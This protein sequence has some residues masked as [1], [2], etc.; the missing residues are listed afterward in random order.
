MAAGLGT[1]LSPATVPISKILLPVF[2]RPMIYY[3][4]SVLMM[5]DIKDILVITNERDSEIFKRLLGD[6]SQFGIKIEYMIQFVQRGISDAFL[7]AK[8]WIAGERVALILGDNI[9]YSEKFESSIKEAITTESGAIIFGY[10]V[11]DPERFGIVE[12]DDDMKVISLEEKPHNPKSNYAVVGLYFYNDQVCDIAKTLKPSSRGELE[13]TDL[14]IEYMNKGDLSAFIID[15][16]TEWI[17]AGTF[18]SILESSLFI[19]NLEKKLGKKVMCPELLAFEKKY[20]SRNDLI[21]WI[22]SNG[23]SDYYNAIRKEIGIR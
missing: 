15:N 1:R 5:A 21:Q 23:D 11:S 19:S 12:F 10:K 8:D 18:D 13:I 4:L 14:N 22:S 20:I 7:I 9:F 17:D 2:D 16:D 6:G 3:P